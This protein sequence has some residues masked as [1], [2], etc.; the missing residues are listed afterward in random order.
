MERVSP[1]DALK[2]PGSSYR[3]KDNL[4]P[5]DRAQLK[6]GD[7]RDPHDILKERYCQHEHVCRE[8]FR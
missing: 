1:L 8:G 7:V 4:N 6:E 5:D 2:N 3:D